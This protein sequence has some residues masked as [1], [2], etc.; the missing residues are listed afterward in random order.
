MHKQ[1]TLVTL[2]LISHI[3]FAQTKESKFSLEAGI[4]KTFTDVSTDYL[5][6]FNFTFGGNY[7][8]NNYVE[9]GIYI[10]GFSTSNYEPDDY[11]SFVVGAQ[12]RIYPFRNSTSKLIKPYLAGRYNN[13]SYKGKNE[14]T[15]LQPEEKFQGKLSELFLLVG[16]Q[17]R[18]IK[19]LNYYIELG[20]D[21]TGSDYRKVT[22]FTGLRYNF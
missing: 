10:G 18:I 5:S 14:K 20:T 4:R 8:F 9:S 19:D 13:I 16:S 2:L 17:V 3:T 6:E 21:V 7:Q 12:L 22:C 11:R 15:E 1:L